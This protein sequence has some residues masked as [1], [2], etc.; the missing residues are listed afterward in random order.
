[1]TC[2]QKGAGSACT[3]DANCAIDKNSGQCNVNPAK[4]AEGMDLGKMLASALVCGFSQAKDEAACKAVEG[5]SCAWRAG[6]DGEMGCTLDQ[7]A[8]LST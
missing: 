2:S 6:D 3:S 7:S 5:S 1:M 8:L 4:V